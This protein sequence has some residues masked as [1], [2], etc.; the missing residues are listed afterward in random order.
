MPGRSLTFIVLIFVMAVAT[1]CN[2]CRKSKVDTMVEKP[3]SI[4]VFTKTAG[5]RHGSIPAGVAMMEQIT[6]KLNWSMTHSEDAALFNPDTLK[7]YG[8]IVFLCTSGT[9]LNEEEKLSL[10]TFVESGGSFLGI[11]SAS[12]TEYDWPW[13]GKMLGA[14]FSDHPHIQEARLYT[15]TTPHPSIMGLPSEWFHTDEYYNFRS[16]EPDIQRVLFVDGTTF[17][18]G[19]HSDNHP[20]SWYK[21]IGKG[22][23]FYCA[24]GHTNESY[25]DSVFQLHIE[26]ALNWLME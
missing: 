6:E 25:E 16:F 21:T 4:L 3:K 22:K 9:I 18:G 23:S 8:I 1:V 2:G 26:N 17:T 10:E 15:S 20:M 12:D 13:Y 24:L 14:W 7:N 11:H 5:F 19:K